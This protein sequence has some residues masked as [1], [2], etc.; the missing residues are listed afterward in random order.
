MIYY[1]S[2]N[3]LAHNNIEIHKI[4]EIEGGIRVIIFNII[5]SILIV[6]YRLEYEGEV[7]C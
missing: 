2:R 7:K 5:C 4:F 3:Y 1:H 6:L